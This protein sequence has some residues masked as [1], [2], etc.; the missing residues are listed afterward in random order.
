MTFQPGQ[1]GNP[2]GYKG[3]RWGNRHKIHRQVLE[4]IQELGH[5]DALITLSE[6]QNDST[7]DDNVRVSAAGLLAPFLHPRLQGIPP[8]RFVPNPID[9]PEFTSVEIAESFLAKITVLVA[10]QELDFQSG[11]E[12]AQMTTA[13]INAQNARTGLELKQISIDGGPSE[14]TIRIEG[15][16]PTLPGCENL[17]MPQLNGNNGYQLLGA[18]PPAI[19]SVPADPDP[20][21]IDS[22]PP[23]G[24]SS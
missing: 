4:K 5:Q 15:G 1:S 6:I 20:A 7:K 17:I 21:T 13:W 22:T 9:V 24:G 11:L 12:L 14:Q 8:P 19:E 2:S 23:D 16:L 3:P 18:D 10:R